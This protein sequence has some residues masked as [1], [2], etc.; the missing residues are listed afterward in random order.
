MVRL[1][2]VIPTLNEEEHLPQLFNALAPLRGIAE[3]IV[4]DGGSTDNTQERAKLYGAILQVGDQGRGGQLHRGAEIATGERL[5]FLHADSLLSPK[6]IEAIQQSL[7][8]P[9]FQIALFRLRF[10]CDDIIYR[11]Y[12]F[13]ARFDS[14]WTTF[15]DQGILINKELYEQLGGFSDLPILEDVDLL[16]RARRRGR[17]KKFSAS[18]TTSARRFE[19]EGQVMLPMEKF[20]PLSLVFARKTARNVV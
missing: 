20:T 17:I 13:F 14:I 4:S 2:I 10:D 16:R 7:H 15:G 12:A 6:A 1:S 9:R 18:I 8:N 5:L 19:R 3:I 11:I